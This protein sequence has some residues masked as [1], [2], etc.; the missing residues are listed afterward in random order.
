[1]LVTVGFI[2]RPSQPLRDA[3]W[4]SDLFMSES[5]LLVFLGGLGGLMMLGASIAV[6]CLL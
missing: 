5:F 1:M 6:L 2:L 4:T 3:V